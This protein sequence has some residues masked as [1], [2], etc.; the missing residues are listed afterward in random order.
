MKA[1][2]HRSHRDQGPQP[3]GSVGRP[4]KGPQAGLH[5]AAASITVWSTTSQQEGMDG[6]LERGI[7]P[8]VG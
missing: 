5:V 1:D 3:C 2:T 7:A 8:V 4:A 6:P